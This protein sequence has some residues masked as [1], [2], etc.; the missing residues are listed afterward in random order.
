M[1]VALIGFGEVGTILAR[2]LHAA[3]H[4]VRV[5]D[6]LLDDPARA[7]S[8]EAK[9][10]GVGATC[11]NSVREAVQ[12]ARV[13][14]SA[15][16]TSSSTAVAQCAGEAL[17]EAQLFLDLNAVS[18][19]TKRINAA[20]V[21]RSGARYVEA[22]VM[23]PIGPAGMA[24]PMLLGG[25]AASELRELLAPA[26]MELEVFPGEIGSASAVKMCRSIMMKGLEALTVECLLTARRYGVE[27]DIIATLERSY[28]QMHWDKLAGYLIGRAVQHGRRRAGEMREAASMIEETGL[29]PFMAAATAQRQDSIADLV[30]LAP[31][32]KLSEARAWRATL[33]RLAALAQLR[34]LKTG[35]E[36]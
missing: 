1:L 25:S 32:L 26:G 29:A 7:A 4:E 9:A 10:Q 28:P 31:E 23:A 15:V 24:T 2:G 30:G 18:P 34:D 12:G 14:I 35:I 16:T 33:D 19:R 5:Y 13:V 3:G 17:R 27:E 11:C 8:L 21:E 20:A 36:S 6:V 22:A